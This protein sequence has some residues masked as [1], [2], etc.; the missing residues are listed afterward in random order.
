M[1]ETEEGG[2]SIGEGIT[3]NTSNRLRHKR[4]VEAR[5]IVDASRKQFGDSGTQM[6]VRILD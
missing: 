5:S 1:Q 3:L 4:I 2:D 6:F